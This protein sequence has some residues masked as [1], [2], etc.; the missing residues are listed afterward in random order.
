MWLRKK[1]AIESV[2]MSI[3][4]YLIFSSPV[5]LFETETHGQYVG[6]FEGNKVLVNLN[7]D[8]PNNTRYSVHF[9][10]TCVGLDEFPEC[11][12]IDFR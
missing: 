8:Y 2:N 12:E 5:V 7:S 6:V 11:W 10:N 9:Q 4:V 1:E 3:A